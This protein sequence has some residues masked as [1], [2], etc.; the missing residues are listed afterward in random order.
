MYLGLVCETLRRGRINNCV[1][2]R[3]EKLHRVRAKGQASSP[4]HTEASNTV[5]SLVVCHLPTIRV[6]D[7]HANYDQHRDACDEVLSATGNLHSLS[8]H[9]QYDLHRR[10]RP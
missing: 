10:V 3:A 1:F 9:S 2:S 8:G 4:I 6:H 5:Q 7:I